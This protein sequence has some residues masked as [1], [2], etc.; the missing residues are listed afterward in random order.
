MK[1]RNFIIGAIQT[2]CYFLIP[3]SSSDVIV[4]DPG[5]DGEGV[6]EKLGEK[7]LKAKYVLL[8]HGH[9]D[10]S[11]GAQMLREAGAKLAVHAEDVELLGDQQKNGALMYFG[12]PRPDYPAPEADIVLSDG[13][14]ISLGEISLKVVHTPGHTKGS[15]CFDGGDAL[16]SGD[17]LF[18]D[19][20]GRTDLFGG[21]LAALSHSL[22]RL[23][24]L[25]GEKKLYPGHGSSSY[26]AREKTNI[27]LFRSR[28]G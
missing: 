21:S 7:G 11:M 14:A 23:G 15:V 25:P 22:V 27:E 3:D 9:F 18:R 5:M 1:I 26:L 8:T 12:S 20:F 17:T 13:D 4:I 19:G 6:L 10:H 16:F 24:D 2:N 28:F